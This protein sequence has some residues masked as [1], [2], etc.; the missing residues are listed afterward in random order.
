METLNLGEE[1]VMNKSESRL[2]G[3]GMKLDKYVGI[4]KVLEKKVEGKVQIK[5]QYR[6]SGVTSS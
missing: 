2:G 4:P 3:R 1:A 5:P 6:N